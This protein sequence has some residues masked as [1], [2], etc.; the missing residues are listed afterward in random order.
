MSRTD[1]TAG[2][3]VTMMKITSAPSTTS[4]M[5]ALKLGKSLGVR[6]QHRTAWPSDIRFFAQALPIMPNPKTEIFI[7]YRPFLLHVAH[8]RACLGNTSFREVTHNNGHSLRRTFRSLT[9]SLGYFFHQL[10]LL[11]NRTAL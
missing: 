7:T 5:D 8:Q 3:S 11:F 1:W 10:P 2:G 6:F 9:D 4:L